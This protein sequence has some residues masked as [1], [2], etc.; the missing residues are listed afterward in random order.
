MINRKFKC[1][2]GCSDCCVFREYYPSDKFGKIGVLLLPEE[3]ESIE[4]QAVQHGY[5]IKILPRIAVGRKY[6]EKVIAYQMMGKNLDGDLCPFLDT[7]SEKRSPHEGFACRIYE[8]RPLA[9]RAYPLISSG[10]A[11][12]L[13]G[14]CR[15]CREH[16][17]T[18]ANAQTLLGEAAA[19]EKIRQTVRVSDD[20]LRIWRYATATGSPDQQTKMLPEGWVM[21]G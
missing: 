16:S 19:L 14:H 5:S 11:V 21:D 6:P 20:S 17:T 1:I 9:C 2:Q 4:K 7:E 3:L 10:D 18:S 8:N 13:D 15:F 12:E